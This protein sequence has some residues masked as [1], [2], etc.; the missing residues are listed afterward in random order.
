MHKRRYK[1]GA[2]KRRAAKDADKEL[3][4]I[5]KLSTY[6]TVKSNVQEQARESDET[7]SE[8]TSRD[9]D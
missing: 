1:S 9:T 4:K 7:D 2:S 3:D 6:F 5:P 8:S